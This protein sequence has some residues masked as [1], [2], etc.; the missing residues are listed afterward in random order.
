MQLALQVA[1]G[2]GQVPAPPFEPRVLDSVG[3]AIEI[4]D[5]SDMINVSFSPSSITAATSGSNQIVRLHVA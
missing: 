4:G 3:E 5:N 1:P 2:P